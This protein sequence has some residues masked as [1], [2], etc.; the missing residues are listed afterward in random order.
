[1]N[2]GYEQG[3]KSIMIYFY[4]C[5][6]AIND[7]ICDGYLDEKWRNYDSY[8]FDYVNAVGDAVIDKLQQT[9]EDYETEDSELAEESNDVVRATIVMDMNLYFNQFLE[10]RVM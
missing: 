3:K 7:L 4:D 2:F 8:D 9:A 10:Y 5:E 1:M 6:G